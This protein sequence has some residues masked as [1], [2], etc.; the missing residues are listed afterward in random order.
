MIRDSLLA[1]ES[2]LQARHL[3]RRDVI[4]GMILALIAKVHVVLL[5]PPGAGKSMLAR[6]VCKRIGGTFFEWLLTRMSTPEELFGPISLR[7]LEQDSY[8]RVTSGK[9]PEADVAFLDECFKASSSILNSLLGV[10]NERVFHNDGQPTSIPLQ[11]MVG[12]S[13]ELPEDR[14]ELGALWDR[15]LLRYVVDWIH[16]PAAF[17][18]MLNGSSTAQ[19]TTISIQDLAQAQAEAVQV[20]I[21]PALPMTVELR[22]RTRELGVGISDRRWHEAMRIVQANAWLCGRAVAQEEDLKVLTAVLWDEPN[23]RAQVAKTVLGLV[24]PFD[25]AADEIMDEA[26]DLYRDAMGA[27]EEE[28]TAKGMEAKKKFKTLARQLQEVI[29]QAEAAGNSGSAAKD[30]LNRVAEFDREVTQKCLGIAV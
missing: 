3:E 14:E 13:N 28:S 1:I 19:R 27:T 24:A 4:H 29:A 22:S 7:A 6:D 8:R 21:T 30:A 16:D 15:F 10:M 11:I 12:A 25:Q 2:E 20:D 23:Q 9:L 17:Q 26:L 18:S 5:G